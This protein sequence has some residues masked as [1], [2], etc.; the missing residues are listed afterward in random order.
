MAERV[1]RSALA[2]FEGAPVPIV[3]C[4]GVRTPE[5]VRAVVAEAAL[6]DSVILHTLVS[7]HLR[8]GI[9][10]EVRIHGVDAMDLLGP[11]LDRLATH[12]RV[13]ARAGVRPRDE[14]ALVHDD[15]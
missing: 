2:Q 8:T 5:Q 7:D 1:A 12:A 11:A 10:Q 3:R 6:R 14:R 15:G 9:L 13:A 4:G